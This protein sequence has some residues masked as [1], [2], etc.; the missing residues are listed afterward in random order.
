MGNKNDSACRF[1]SIK[2]FMGEIYG[3]NRN[4]QKS[5]S[6]KK[7]MNDSAKK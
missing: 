2:L 3:K 4:V 1:T 7:K 6:K 5:T